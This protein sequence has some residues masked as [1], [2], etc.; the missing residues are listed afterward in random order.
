MPRRAA[1][2]ACFTLASFAMLLAAA[3][4]AASAKGRLTIGLGAGSPRAGQAFTVYVRTDWALAPDDWLRLIAVAPGRS[5]RDVVPAV[6]GS[7]ATT[8]ASLPRDG[9][10]I[11]LT[12]AD[13]NR[14]RAVVR[15]PRTGRWRLVVPNG[16]HIGYMVPPPS[17]WMPW[18]VVRPRTS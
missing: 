17:S 18:V 8:R 3:V 14:W 4:P 5:W 15:L 9:F 13:A 6:F 7:P 12:R 2:V 16:T 1:T 10:E 11:K